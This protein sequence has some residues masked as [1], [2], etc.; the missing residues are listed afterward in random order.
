MSNPTGAI[1]TA[2]SP[3]QTLGGGNHMLRP[4]VRATDSEGHIFV[5]NV[6]FLSMAAVV[7][8]HCIGG[9]GALA[10]M[11]SADGLLRGLLQPFKFGTIGFFLIS[12]FLMGEGLTRRG[13]WEYLK[14][15]LER[16]LVPWFLWC[17]IFVVIFVAGDI[18]RGR[19]NLHFTRDATISLV[20]VVRGCMFESAYWF[21][22]NLLLALCV[23]L[24]FRRVLYDL[25]VGCVL[26][27]ISVFY[28]LNLHA[29][30]LPV[31]SHTQAL[32][33][34]VFYLWLGVWA[35]RNFAAVDAWISQTSTPMLI[36][37][38]VL[39]CLAALRESEVLYSMGST[40]VV[41]TLR[42][43][44]QVYSVA[45][46]LVI[47]KLRKAVWPRAMDV[48]T[49]TFGIYLTHSIVLVLAVFIIKRALLR[50]FG[51][52]AWTS[53]AEVE[54]CLSFLTFAV[55]YGSSLALTAWL[56]NQPRL[57]WMVGALPPDRKAIK[58]PA[59]E[60][61]PEFSVGIGPVFATT[62]DAFASV[63]SAIPPPP[64]AK[65]GTG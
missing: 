32:F 24:F 38:A 39:A 41:N 35:A 23:L 6:R 27:A 54:I 42:L 8:V 56:L 33:G 17:S 29:R 2:T 12:G 53:P 62:P 44:N 11:S 21:V 61:F 40:S 22:P 9:V 25:R 31:H 60:P 51:E 1:I 20:Q 46:V 47:V 28:G 14:R 43:S 7:L 26:L 65:S 5:D 36:V 49:C 50:A 15:R 52:A 4:T 45:A 18:D 3:P 48:R 34:F 58:A 55:T 13:S 63:L 16:V 64:I 57:S 59:R 10:G 37:A 30:W 19:L